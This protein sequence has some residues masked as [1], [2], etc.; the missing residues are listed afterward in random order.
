MCYYC[1]TNVILLE[2]E[3]P[4]IANWAA[5]KKHPVIAAGLNMHC[6][7]IPNA[8]YGTLRRHTN[9]VEQSANQSYSYGTRQWLLPAILNAQK[10]DQRHAAQY[11]ARKE[12]GIS[13]TYRSTALRER[14]FTYI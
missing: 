9:A 5:H 4:T 2:F 13:H 10:L 11:V 14:L 7:R 3:N 8:I 12:W 1:N 6:S